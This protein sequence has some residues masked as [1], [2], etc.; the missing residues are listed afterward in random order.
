MIWYQVRHTAGFHLTV[1]LRHQLI[2]KNAVAL[3]DATL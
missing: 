1:I 3:Q 2:A